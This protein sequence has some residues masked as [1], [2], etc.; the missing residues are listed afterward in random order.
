VTNPA[1]S[2]TSVPVDPYGPPTPRGD[3]L[4]PESK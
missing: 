4:P 1:T 2:T 3:A